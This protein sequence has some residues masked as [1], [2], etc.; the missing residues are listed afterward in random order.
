MVRA[1]TGRVREWLSKPWVRRS[2]L[3]LGVVGLIFAVFLGVLWHRLWDTYTA[4]RL[5]PDLLAVA[6]PYF[7]W[8][9]LV[10][11]N[12]R[13]YPELGTPARDALLGLATRA[14]DAGR[15]DLAWPAEL[16]R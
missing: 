8:R 6:P 11:C 1:R 12:P 14:L 10:V 15:L 2:L 9:A 7:A 5:D 16:M 3:G 4:A 13:F